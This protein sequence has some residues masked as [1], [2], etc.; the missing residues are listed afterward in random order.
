MRSFIGVSLSFSW[1]YSAYFMATVFFLGAAYALRVGGHVRVALL[2]ELLPPPSIVFL[3]S[4]R[5]LLGLL[6]SAYAAVAVSKLA[7]FR[8]ERGTTSFTPTRTLLF[9]PQG[10]VALGLIMLSA[11]F[12]ARLLRLAM[13]ST[14]RPGSASERCGSRSMTTIGITVTALLLGLLAGGVWISLALVRNRD[15]IIVAL[16]E[17]AGRRTPWAD[18]LEYSHH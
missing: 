18:H 2:L 5:R 17:H 10:L 12:V 3:S 8:F 15:C 13:R 6:I 16:P 4:F 1:E 14:A 9:V 7:L 11:Q